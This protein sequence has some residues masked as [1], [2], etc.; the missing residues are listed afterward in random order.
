MEEDS[1]Q[2]NQTFTGADTLT[3]ETRDSDVCGE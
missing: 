3:K 2:V 1:A